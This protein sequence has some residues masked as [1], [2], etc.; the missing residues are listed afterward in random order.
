MQLR[1]KLPGSGGARLAFCSP[2]GSI[3]FRFFSASSSRS[4]RRCSITSFFFG[5]TRPLS[6][7]LVVQFGRS[8]LCA[9]CQRVGIE[10]RWEQPEQ[11]SLVSLIDTGREPYN[12][13]GES[14]PDVYNLRFGADGGEIDTLAGGAARSGPYPNKRFRESKLNGLWLISSA[15]RWAPPT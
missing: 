9:L 10:W 2:G 8:S 12:L 3:A 14:F 7:N 6:S 13:D 4:R 1:Q 15:A 11:G 5:R